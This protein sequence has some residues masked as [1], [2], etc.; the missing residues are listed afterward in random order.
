[1]LQ[2]VFKTLK[3]EKNDKGFRNPTIVVFLTENMYSV[4]FTLVSVSHFGEWSVPYLDRLTLLI[5]W[6]VTPN[7]QYSISSHPSLNREGIQH[8]NLHPAG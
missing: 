4:D 7:K 3:T 2:S 5:L 1:M 6:L 8:G